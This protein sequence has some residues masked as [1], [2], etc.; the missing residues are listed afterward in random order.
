MD[1]LIQSLVFH[2]EHLSSGAESRYGNWL[3][4][5]A[6]ENNIHVWDLSSMLADT[7][8]QPTILVTPTVVLGAHLAR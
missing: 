8:Q 4:T 6:S 7:S 2:P 3:A 1:Q 5:A